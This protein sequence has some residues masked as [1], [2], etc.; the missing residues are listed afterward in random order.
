MSAHAP[1]PRNAERIA[2]PVGE[3]ELAA[4]LFRPEVADDQPV[5]PV[6][7]MAHGFAGT[8]DESL[9]RYAQRFAAA[10]FAVLAFDYRSFG[11]SGGWPRQVLDIEG[12]LQ[13]WRAAIDWVRGNDAFDVS[14]ISLWGSSF[15]GGHVQQLAAN[16]DSI[17]AVIAQVPFADGQANTGPIGQA[18]KLI[19]AAL[20]DHWR[21]RRGK[22]PYYIACMGY[23]G[24]VA[25]M[26]SADAMDQGLSF[27]SPVSLWEN[28]VAARVILQILK[29][30]PGLQAG[31]IRCP[32][33]YQLGDKD[34]VTPVQP[35]LAA[36]ERAP[37]ATVLNYP[38][39]HFEIYQGAPFEIAVADQ[40][41]FLQ[42]AVGR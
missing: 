35:V 42:A 2:I 28:R 20:R 26:T 31:K 34:V 17:R 40:I 23:P 25:V 16:D 27:G 24:Q 7:V 36:A 6:V 39:E 13:D 8:V 37:Q 30:R 33:L 5:S 1:V 22:Y 38:I 9:T 32:I 3:V 19:F 15:A 29:Y 21:A 12:Q 41:R 18:L 4:W 14:A 10:G 11:A